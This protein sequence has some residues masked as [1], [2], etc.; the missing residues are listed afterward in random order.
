MNLHVGERFFKCKHY[1]KAFFKKEN[2][3]LH[4]KTHFPDK[5]KVKSR[6]TSALI[7]M[8]EY[9]SHFKT[10]R[11]VEI[12][13]KSISKKVK[14]VNSVI[15]INNGF[16]NSISNMYKNAI[17]NS[18]LEDPSS[19]C[20]ENK[21][22]NKIINKSN[23]QIKKQDGKLSSNYFDNKLKVKKN[24]V[25]EIED[26]VSVVLS[27]SSA[28]SNKSFDEFNSSHEL[29]DDDCIID[30]SYPDFYF[31][32]NESPKRISPDIDIF[33]EE[34]VSTSSI[35]ETLNELPNLSKC[36]LSFN[37]VK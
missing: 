23:L 33:D 27:I 10:L 11:L 14:N 22:N 28:S 8:K 18:K 1:E 32:Y 12:K 13:T 37:V 31:P 21:F 24:P 16:H 17:Q 20:Y 19:E 25:K 3:I 30:E 29:E 34:P 7:Q 36:L 15:S 5:S 2:I 35:S 4:L 6:Q 9:D 26:S